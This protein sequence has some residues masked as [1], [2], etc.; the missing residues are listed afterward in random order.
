MAWWGLKYVSSKK[1]RQKFER[2]ADFTTVDHLFGWQMLE[3]SFYTTRKEILL[4]MK[5]SNL[6]TETK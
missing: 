4:H 1:Y 6:Y 5:Q 3:T 2:E